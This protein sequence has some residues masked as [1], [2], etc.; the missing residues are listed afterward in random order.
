MIGPEVSEALC[1]V[2]RMFAQPEPLMYKLVEFQED[3]WESYWWF[4][5]VWYV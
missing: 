1:I 2:I 4:A 5:Y 3:K